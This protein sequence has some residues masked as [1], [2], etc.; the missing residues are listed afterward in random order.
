METGKRWMIY[1]ANGYTGRLCACEAQRRHMQPILA[2]RTAD[3]VGPM[4]R[5]FGFESRVFDLSRPDEAARRLEGVDTVLNCAGPFSRTARPMLEACVRSKTNYLDITGEIDVFEYVQ[6]RDETWKKAGIAVIPGVGFD[7]VPSDCLAAML[8][9]A[10][11]DAQRL[12]MAFRAAAMKLSP[13]TAKTV[14]EGVADGCRI[15]RGGR[16]ASIPLGSKTA[17]IPFASGPAL[18]VA[19]SWGDV[20]TAYYSTG[21][22]DIEVYLASTPGQVRQLKTLQRFRWIVGARAVQR[23]LHWLISKKVNGPTEAER[24]V[25]WAELYGEVSNAEG[26]RAAMVMRTP[27]SYDLTSD[28][29]VTAAG[30][31]AQGIVAPG[32]HTPS[33]AFGAEFVLGLRG[34]TCRRVE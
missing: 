25:S 7:V 11:P 4:A 13:G 24:A 32:A 29:A 21:I 5:D 15:R 6:A 34:V 12:V 20:S 30:K 8:K 26:K 3:S 9:H 10:L 22:P 16:I 31:V 27:E 28:S 19:I 14:A 23:L 33:N 18:A 1:G 17:T 2:G